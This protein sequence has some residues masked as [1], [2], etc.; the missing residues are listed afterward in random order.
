M[1]RCD[2][3]EPNDPLRM[4]AQ[5]AWG[6]GVG[7]PTCA[8]AAARRNDGSG[9]GIGQ[10]F[11]ELRKAK[12]ICPSKVA[13]ANEEAGPKDDLIAL[14]KPPE[15]PQHERPIEGSGGCHDSNAVAR[16]KSRGD[17]HSSF[18]DAKRLSMTTAI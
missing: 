7:D 9:P 1:K 3:R 11:G 16:S 2:V 17:D 6:H 18:A 4:V 15:P 12:R 8:I 10:R 13:V 5:G 14:A